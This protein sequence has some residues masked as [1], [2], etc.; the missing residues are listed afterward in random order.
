MVRSK[1]AKPPNH[2]STMAILGVVLPPLDPIKHLES[3]MENYTSMFDK[4]LQAIQDAKMAK[5]A[6]LG[7]IQVNICLMREAHAKLVEWVGDPDSSLASLM[8]SM[9]NIQD[10]LHALWAE[11]EVLQA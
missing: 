7:A 2:K 1:V 11:V 10:Q 3:T 4:I 5:E 9:K 8:P 6:P